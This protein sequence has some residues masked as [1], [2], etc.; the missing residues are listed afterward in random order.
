LRVAND[1]AEKLLG[2][3]V[4]VLLELVEVDFRVQVL[5]EAPGVAV[6]RLRLSLNRRRDDADAVH[7]VGV[8]LLL[9]AC[10]LRRSNSERCRAEKNVA[11]GRGVSLHFA[12]PM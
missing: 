2:A 1:L 9:R 10:R 7:L 8:G 11:P 6:E 3:G 5:R 4:E 12:P